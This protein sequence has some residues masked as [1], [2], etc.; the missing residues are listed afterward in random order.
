MKNLHLFAAL[1][2]AILLV[3][4]G[5][6]STSSTSGSTSALT[7]GTTSTTGTTGTSSGSLS[8]PS[9]THIEAIVSHLT[10]FDTAFKS[11][12]IVFQYQDLATIQSLDQIQFQL[13]YYNGAGT[14]VVLPTDQ[15]T[16]SDTSQLYGTLSYNSGT[17]V[18][19]N[20][21]TPNPLVIQAVYNNATFTANYSV[22]ARQVRLRGLV[23]SDVTHTRLSGIE[24]D[25]YG[26]SNI[27]NDTPYAVQTVDAVDS[28]G[29]L[30]PYTAY[31]YP[32]AYNGSNLVFLGKTTTQADG[33]IRGSVPSGTYGFTL[34][35]STLP[36]G[37]QRIFRFKG[38]L[39]NTSDLN[40]LGLAPIPTPLPIVTP[41]AGG[42][43]NPLPYPISAAVRAELPLLNNYLPNGE[44]YLSNYTGNTNPV[45]N[46]TI[47]LIPNSETVGTPPN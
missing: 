31:S 25:F 11:Q 5:G 12:G 8:A 19:G 28:L 33:T 29:G 17:Y 23:E 44:Y 38:Q 41:P 1:G 2:V 10:T 6:S 45:T 14:R 35:N 3:A 21:T 27:T 37:Y 26:F 47:E 7:T 9:G 16:S 15:W 4:C 30:H 42:L 32:T 24:V 46:G 34:V 43:P 22:V 39:Y 13:V 20:A 36:L 18:A 40:P